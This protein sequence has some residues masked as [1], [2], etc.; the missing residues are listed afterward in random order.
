M[1]P[2]ESQVD[3]ENSSGDESRPIRLADSNLSERA[4]ICAFFKSPEDADRM[5]LPFVK[6]G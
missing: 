3:S 4:H 2:T 6:E 5:L 1:N